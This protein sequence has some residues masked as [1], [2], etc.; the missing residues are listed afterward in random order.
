MKFVP[1]LAG[2]STSTSYPAKTSHHSLNSE[3]LK[4]ANISKGLIRI[5]AGLEDIRD[6]IDEF[7]KTISEI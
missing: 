2:V 3:E 7:D 4:K 1:S 5:S 6:I